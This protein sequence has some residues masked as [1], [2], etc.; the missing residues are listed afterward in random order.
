MGLR[1]RRLR[2]LT[3][4]THGSYL[5]YL[6]QAPHDFYV[7]SLPGRPPGY[8]G[9]C[10]DHAWGDNVFDQP[11]DTV[12]GRS[13]DCVLFQDD[14][15]FFDDQHRYLSNAQRSLPRIYVEHDPPRAHPTDTRHPVDDP[16]VLL[17]QVTSFNALMWD[18]GRT[19]HI[20][21]EHGITDPGQRWRGELARGITVINHLAQRGRR[22]GADLFAQ[23][24]EQ[25]PLDLLGMGSEVLGGLGERPLRQVP[26]VCAA[27]RFFFHPVRYTS[28]GLGLLEA[29]MLGMPVVALATTETPKLIE[30]GVSGVVDTSLSGLVDGMRELLRDYRLATRLGEQARR[31]A[32]QR[33]SIARFVAD[34][35]RALS[36]IA[37]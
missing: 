23:V 32:M 13:F 26:E 12:Q 21:I 16:N 25:L 31:Q 3:W 33:H 36:G 9:R 1:M 22:L 17:V 2:I 29:M 24:R 14:A 30:H 28:L 5:Y 15:Q 35:N 19:P 18:A 10:G 4:H 34:W 27:Y 20:V 11:V 8:G 37:C 6:S 7:L